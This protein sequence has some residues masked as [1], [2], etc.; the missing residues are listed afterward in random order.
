[1]GVPA[2]WVTRLMGITTFCTLSTGGASAP[3]LPVVAGG[4]VVASAD[5]EESAPSL[6][7][8]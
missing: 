7:T 1:M 8:T 2:C 4:R 6:V 3:G 5:G